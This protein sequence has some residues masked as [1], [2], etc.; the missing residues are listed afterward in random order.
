MAPSV[1]EV[2]VPSTPA[3]V[4]PGSKEETPDSPS[5]ILPKEPLKPSG[6]L[7]QFDHFDV[8]PVIGR[9]FPSAN[10]KEWLHAPNSDELIRDLAITGKRYLDVLCGICIRNTNLVFCTVSQRG[11][12]FFRQQDE[13]DNDLQKELAQRLGQ[14][15]GKPSTSALH[16]HPVVNSVREFGGKDDRISV[17]SSEHAKKI[18]KDRFGLVARNKQSSKEHWHSDITFEPVPSDYSIL[19]LTQIPKTGGG[20]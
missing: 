6:V 20:A 18:Y 11:V 1:A 16:I 10:L 14:L 15:S 3:D 8:T 12:V 13:L 2:R 5:R 7:E 9:E 17:I 19:R 4:K